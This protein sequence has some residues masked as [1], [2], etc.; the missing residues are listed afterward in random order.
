MKRTM[1]P[2]QRR[3]FL[4]KNIVL[5]IEEVND[6][7]SV[8]VLLHNVHQQN[9]P[10]NSNII[11]EAYNRVDIERLQLGNVADYQEEER[12]HKLPFATPLRS[13]INFRLKIIDPHSFKLLGY[14][15]NLKEEKYATS[16]LEIDTDNE[17]VKNIYKIDLD[18]PQHPVFHLNPQLKPVAEQLKPLLA[19]MALKDIL[20]HLLA[21]D[22]DEALED[23]KWFHFANRLCPYDDTE[24]Q[25]DP[26]YNS[27]WINRVLCAFAEKN[28]LIKTL[29]REY[30]AD[31]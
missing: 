12:S 21:S 19:E 5:N 2:E 1:A 15:E 4:Q 3:K 25:H 28:K 27:D 10:G 22:E 17:R 31:G 13:K 29:I 24:K 30:R 20:T 11:L 16:M 8:K 18:N 6:Q 9:Y 23:N 7:L 14:A 26:E